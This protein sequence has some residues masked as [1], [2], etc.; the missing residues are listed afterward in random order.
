M[1][2][3]PVLDQQTSYGPRSSHKIEND[4]RKEQMLTVRTNRC[5]SLPGPAQGGVD[6]I[7][8]VHAIQPRLAPG[9]EVAV[10]DLVSEL[11]R[12]LLRLMIRL[13]PDATHPLLRDRAVPDVVEIQLTP[14]PQHVDPVPAPG[15]IFVVQG[16]VNVSDKVYYKL[17]G[18]RAEP[19]WNGGVENLGGV[20]LDR[21]YY[22]TFFLAVAVEIDGAVI[23]RLVFGVDEMEHSCVVAP[24]RVPDRV[25]PGGYV[26]EI[27]AGVVPEEGLEVGLCLRLD[28]VASKIC[29]CDMPKA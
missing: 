2:G 15:H 28:E 5:M 27:V 14:L 4:K 19:D 22:A 25:G 26:C 13:P 7:R 21:R 24:F 12:P 11:V 20:V 9:L 17:S 29:D 18:L 8:E 6:G 23:R 1:N 16:L 3:R 10:P